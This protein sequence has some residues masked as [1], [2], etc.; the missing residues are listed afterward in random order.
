MLGASNAKFVGVDG[1][2]AGWFSIG[3]G[4]GEGHELEVFGEFAQLVHHFSSAALILVD[5]PIGLRDSGPGERQCDMKARGMVGPRRSSVF[6]APV[7]QALNEATF[8]DASRVNRSVRDKGISK[9]TWAIMPKIAEVDCL[10]ATVPTERERV[11]EV[12]P[13]LLFWALNGRQAMGHNKR[14]VP[15]RNE[16]MAVLRRLEP[17]AQEVF[18]RALDRWLRKEVARDDILDALAAAV[19]AREGFRK[20]LQ[21]VPDNPP[22]DAYGLPM[23]MVFYNPHP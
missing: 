9:Q 7:R 18:E 14:K 11:R 13:E 4:D 20:K 5:I 15:G 12:H 10:L 8:E 21:T 16:R 2:K 6:P 3:L 17:S 22:K 23:E 1:C 19:T